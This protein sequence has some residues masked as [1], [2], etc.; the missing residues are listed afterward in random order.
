MADCGNMGTPFQE[1][2]TGRIHKDDQE[3]EGRG[4]RFLHLDIR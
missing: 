2:P 4:D 3:R 1:I